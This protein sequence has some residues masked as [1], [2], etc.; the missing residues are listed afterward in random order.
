MADFLWVVLVL[1]GRSN[2]GV[3]LMVYANPDNKCCS[4]LALQNSPVDNVKDCFQDGFGVSSE[5]DFMR[6]EADHAEGKESLYL[7][8]A[9]S[10]VLPG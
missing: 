8:Q 7:Y 3:S 4:V 9:R 10:W 5:L 1:G 2:M 6:L